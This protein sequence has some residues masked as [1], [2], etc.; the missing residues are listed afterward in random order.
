MPIKTFEIEV[1]QKVIIKL[2]TDKF[3]PEFMEEFSDN[4][5]AMY[6]IEDHVEHLAQLEARGILNDDFIEGY[7]PP[8]DMGISVVD[9]TVTEMQIIDSYV[10]ADDIGNDK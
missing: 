7:G 6:S 1:A 2:D 4:F 10:L 5:Y 9:T 8:Q 3:T